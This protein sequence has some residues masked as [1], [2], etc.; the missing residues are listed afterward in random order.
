[1]RAATSSPEMAALTL[2]S[3]CGSGIEAAG[4]HPVHKTLENS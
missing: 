3:N 1:M 4:V 2:V